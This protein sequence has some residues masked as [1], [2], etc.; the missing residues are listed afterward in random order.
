MLKMKLQYFHHLMQRTDSLENTLMLGKI[1]GR[2][3]RGDRGWDG[4]MVS[5]ARWTW[6][7]ASSKNWWCTGKPGMLQSMG[8]QRVGH[9]WVTELNWLNWI[10]LMVTTQPTK[11]IFKKWSWNSSPSRLP[12]GSLVSKPAQYTASQRPWRGNG[13]ERS[14]A[15]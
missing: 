2:K 14:L 13:S 12:P 9:D 5:P 11:T 8:S 15:N 3:R 7:W 10:L 1:E 6:V 4:W